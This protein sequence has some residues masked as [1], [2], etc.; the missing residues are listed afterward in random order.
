MD[1]YE[2]HPGTHILQVGTLWIIM[3]NGN[4]YFL[5][6]RCIVDICETHQEQMNYYVAF[7]SVL[8]SLIVSSESIIY[9][10]SSLEAYI[11][12]SGSNAGEIF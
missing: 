7:V 4:T 6:G 9:C 12:I 1:N 3:K 10:R 8:V 11:F 5:I 2:T